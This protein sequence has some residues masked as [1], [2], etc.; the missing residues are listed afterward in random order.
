MSRAWYLTGLDV[1]TA[2]TA[3]V[4]ACVEGEQVRCVAVATTASRGVR[5]GQVSELEP[6]IESVRGVIEQLERQAERPV[7]AAVVA[8]GARL[9]TVQVRESLTLGNRPREVRAE[10]VRR[11][12]EAARQNAVPDGSE[13]LHVF[14]R[15]F[16]LDRFDGIRDPIGMV[17]SRL[18]AAVLLPVVPLVLMQNLVVAVNRAGLLVSDAVL[19]SLAAAESTLSGDERELGVAL[20]DIGAGSSNLIAYGGGAVHH[21]ASIPIGGEH[22]THDLAVGLR[23]P[24]EEAERVK[25]EQGWA[26]TEL[27]D[28]NAPVTVAGLGEREPQTVFLRQ[29]AEILEARAA[30]LLELVRGELL[31]VRLLNALPGGLVLTGGGARLRGLPQLA[32]KMLGVPVRVGRPRFPEGIPE[33]FRQPEFAV[34]FGLVSYAARAH[35]AQRVARSWWE[36]LRTWFGRADHG[37]IIGEEA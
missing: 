3:A 14:P 33:G 27:L 2:K 6:V 36:R 21:T 8:L 10:D 29:V 13:V 32:E 4:T 18:E 26:W 31:R 35:R 34:L 11:V 30:E 20:V 17:G 7:K 22:F 16:L 5:R 23:V 12:L 19:G 28:D 24:V 37:L 9:Q 15:E 1:G 25:K